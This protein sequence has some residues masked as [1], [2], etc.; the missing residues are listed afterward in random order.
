MELAAWAC[1]SPGGLHGA[2]HALVALVPLIAR[3]EPSDVGGVSSPLHP[4]TGCPTVLVYDAYPGGIGISSTLH[5]RAR[6]WVAR[7]VE[8]LASCPCQDG[9][10][11]CVLS[12]RC[13]SGN[14]PMDKAAAFLLLQ[15]WLAHDGGGGGG[16][17]EAPPPEEAGPR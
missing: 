6:D 11:R 14:E 15:T 8:L 9:C 4:D 13:G 17:G 12:P 1:P 10:P 2:E 7:V 16:A 5:S 3:C